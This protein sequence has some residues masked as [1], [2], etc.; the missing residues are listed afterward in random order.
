MLFVGCLWA[1][2]VKGREGLCQLVFTLILYYI[3][4]LQLGGCISVGVYIDIVNIMPTIGEVF[5]FYWV[6][7][8]I[9]YV[10]FM[11]EEKYLYFVWFTL[12]LYYIYYIL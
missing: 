3:S 12:I 5:V 8:D 4:Y 1:L 6:D 9:V 11:K 10:M 2:H 7:I